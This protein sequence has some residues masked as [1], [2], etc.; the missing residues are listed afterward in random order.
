MTCSGEIRSPLEASVQRLCNTRPVEVMCTWTNASLQ[1]PQVNAIYSLPLTGRRSPSIQPPPIWRRS[2]T[3]SRQGRRVR[4][5]NP[6]LAG[7]TCPIGLRLSSIAATRRR[8]A[9]DFSLPCVQW[10]SQW[11]NSPPSRQS[12]LSREQRREGTCV[13]SSAILRGLVGRAWAKPTA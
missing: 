11:L 10:E 12:L 13:S 6:N 2:L 8:S 7:M 5:T 3:S 4:P 1:L 9:G